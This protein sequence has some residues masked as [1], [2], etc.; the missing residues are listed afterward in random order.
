MARSSEKSPA[1]PTRGTAARIW[2]ALALLVDIAAVGILIVT[3]YAGMLSPLRYG[4]VWG[5]LPLGFPIAFWIVVGLL[6]VQLFVHRRGAVVCALGLV[7]CAGPALDYCPL[8]FGTRKAPEGAPTFTL[9]TFNAHQFVP[10]HTNAIPKTKADNSAPNPQMD[11]ILS[12]D[13][14]IVC[15]QEATYICTDLGDNLISAAQLKAM[16]EKYPHILMAMSDILL[17]SKFPV[18]AIHLD[19]NPENFPGGCLGCYRV[20][21]PSGRIIT[22]FDVHLHSMRLRADDK[23]LYMSLTELHRED[24][25]AVR[26]QLLRKLSSAAEGR[27]R[28]LIQL[29]RYIRLYGGPDVIIAGDFNDVSGCHTIRALADAGF[30]SVYPEV[31]LGPVITFNSDRL[32]FG[33]DHILYRGAFMPLSIEKGPRCGSDHYPLLATFAVPD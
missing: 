9:L 4:G 23:E 15:L 11:Y 12:A 5:V 14:D 26:D 22:I 7:I 18:E 8:N 19:A 25:G 33:I 6:A 24:L 2:R 30:R 13:A 16:H 29:Q 20:T 1:K 17:M 32:Y 21:L 10:P 3:G 31:G 27:T 28:D